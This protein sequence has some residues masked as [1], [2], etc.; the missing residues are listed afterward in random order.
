[1]W[2]G[3]T[4]QLGKA[5][6]VLTKGNKIQASTP[7]YRLSTPAD[8]TCLQTNLSITG[9][10]RKIVLQSFKLPVEPHEAFPVSSLPGIIVDPYPFTAQPEQ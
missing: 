2:W 7:S 6:A 1:M 10:Q 9:F 8:S 3:S 4:F 5:V